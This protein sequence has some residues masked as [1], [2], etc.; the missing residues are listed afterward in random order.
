MHLLDPAR[1]AHE[2]GQLLAMAIMEAAQDVRDQFGAG[3]VRQSSSSLDRVGLHDLKP[4]G[5]AF[6]IDAPPGR[7]FAQAVLAAAAEIEL[8]LVEQLR[9]TGNAARQRTEGLVEQS[10]DGHLWMEEDSSSSQGQ[11]QGHPG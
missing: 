3:R 11:C 8:V 2:F 6:C 4:V 5:D 7:G 1:Q 10:H 9:G